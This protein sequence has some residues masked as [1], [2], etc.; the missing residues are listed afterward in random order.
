M[1]KPAPSAEKGRPTKA[2]PHPR[3]VEERGEQKD[4]GPKP[5]KKLYRGGERVT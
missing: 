4:S 1:K 5:T 2:S 3:V